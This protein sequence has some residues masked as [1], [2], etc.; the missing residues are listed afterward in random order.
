MEARQNLALQG[1]TPRP[2]IRETYHDRVGN[3]DTVVRGEAEEVKAES[4]LLVDV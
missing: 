4:I 3:V 2:A 1:E